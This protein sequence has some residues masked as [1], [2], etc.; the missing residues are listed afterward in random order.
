MAV[1]ADIAGAIGLDR[2]RI[3]ADLASDLDKGEIEAEIAEA[4][5]LGVSG[6]PFFIFARSFAVSGAQAADVLAQAIDRARS[7]VP[8]LA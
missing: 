5:R 7:A 2:A 6:V 4:A 1:L 8:T 3:A